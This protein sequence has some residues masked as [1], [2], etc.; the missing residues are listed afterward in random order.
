MDEL[1]SDY[2][3][4]KESTL[5]LALRL[6]AGMQNYAE[7]HLGSAEQEWYDCEENPGENLG[8]R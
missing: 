5:H 7:I 1:L 6:R 2:N 8:K 4:Q 3:I